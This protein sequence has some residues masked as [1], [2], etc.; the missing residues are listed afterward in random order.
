MPL[1]KQV[2]CALHP[3]S[4]ISHVMDTNPQKSLDQFIE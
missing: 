1:P 3:R 2:I 4:Q